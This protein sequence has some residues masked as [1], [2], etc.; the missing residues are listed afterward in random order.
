MSSSRRSLR[1]RKISPGS[2][3]NPAD[4]IAKPPD[5]CIDIIFSYLSPTELISIQRVNKTWRDSVN[6]R[7]SR[8][9]YWKQWFP[10]LGAG[11]TKVEYD[12]WE[13]AAVAFRRA[14]KI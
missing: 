10:P 13:E 14:G 12:T 1:L 11:D 6:W 7:F 3:N 8:A 4:P 5:L 2:I 9:A